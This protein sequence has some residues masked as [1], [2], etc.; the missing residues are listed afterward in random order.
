[1]RSQ[2]KTKFEVPGFRQADPRL[3]GTWISDNRRTFAEWNR[4]GKPPLEKYKRLRALFGPCEI[5]YTPSR[6]VKR[7]PR[8]NFETSQKYCVLAVDETSV[9]IL[10]FGRLETKNRRKYWNEGLEI[11]QEIK[12]EI[13]HIHFVKEHYWISMGNAGS[14]EFYRRIGARSSSQIVS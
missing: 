8:H 12:P 7:L 4:K 1:L 5:K 9:A 2:A 14:R 6:V 13:V 10:P 11:V 3:I